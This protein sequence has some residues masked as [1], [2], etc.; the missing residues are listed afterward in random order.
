MTLLP[1]LAEGLGVGGWSEREWD[2][3]LHSRRKIRQV[4]T[5]VP[6]CTVPG[7]SLISP[8]SLSTC[9]QQILPLHTASVPPPCTSGVFPWASTIPSITGSTAISDWDPPFE[10][11]QHPIRV[12][13]YRCGCGWAVLAFL[14]CWW[15]PQSWG[16]ADYSQGVLLF[17]CQ[18]SCPVQKGSHPR[19]ARTSHAHMDRQ[20]IS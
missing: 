11:P 16:D 6:S 19:A 13:G 10:S 5:A 12:H 15:L 7:V 4:N 14:L 20:Q 1:W 3:Y 18:G 9:T 8:R 17:W 2:M